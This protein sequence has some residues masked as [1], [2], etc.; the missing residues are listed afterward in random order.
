MRVSG[1]TLLEL[2]ITIALVAVLASFAIP[3]FQ[4]TVQNNRLLSCSNKLAAAVQFAKS[5]AISTKQTILVESL[6]NPNGTPLYRV[7]S[8]D[9]SNNSVSDDELLQQ[10]SCEGEGLAA[11]NSLG[12]SFISFGPT[13]FRNDGF[14]EVVFT[15]CNSLKKGKAFRVSIGG[16]VSSSDVPSGSCT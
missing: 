8:D 1:F 11:T 14:G 6:L 12:A 2:M 3:A 5:E 10:L 9:D 16:A 7:G 15:T 13:G 4:S